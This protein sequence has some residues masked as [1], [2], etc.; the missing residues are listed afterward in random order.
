MTYMKIRGTEP[1]TCPNPTEEGYYWV[2]TH[3][4]RYAPSTAGMQ[5]PSNSYFTWEG[6][7]PSKWTLAEFTNDPCLWHTTGSDECIFERI[8]VIG[9]KIEPPKEDA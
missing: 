5:E 8:V 4:P 7:E 1:E 6:S 2:K 3:E 9:P